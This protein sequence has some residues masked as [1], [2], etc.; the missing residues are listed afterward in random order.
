MGILSY[1]APV[2]KAFLLERR[3]LLEQLRELDR[4]EATRG[5][6]LHRMHYTIN[7]FFDTFDLYDIDDRLHLPHSD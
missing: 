3:A 1:L 4:R 5:N 2:S 6:V 7:Y